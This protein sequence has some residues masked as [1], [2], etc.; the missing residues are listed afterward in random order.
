MQISLTI[1][2]PPMRKNAKHRI[3]V[4]SGK[5]NGRTIGRQLTDEYKRFCQ[6]VS[7]VW[8]R[9]RARLR[10]Q[11]IEAGA[12][13][14]TVRAYWSSERHLDD[15]DLPLGDV[16]APLECTLDALA[17]AG[18][19]DDDVRFVELRTTKHYDKRNPR[20]EVEIRRAQGWGEQASLELPEF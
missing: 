8:D 11:K 1:P 12:W 3:Y 17:D 5:G 18:A 6:V 15:I 4:R 9:E 16:D 19:I 2:G 7:L 20:T 10:L 14:I 13:T